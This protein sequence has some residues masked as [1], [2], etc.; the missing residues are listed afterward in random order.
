MRVRSVSR[1][2]LFCLGCFFFFGFSPVLV[3]GRG[4]GRER[5]REYKADRGKL[6]DPNIL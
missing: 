1:S 2:Q 5:E 3:G 4:G 6:E